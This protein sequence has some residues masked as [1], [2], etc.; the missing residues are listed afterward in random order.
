MS[1]YGALLPRHMG[2]TKAH[3]L[4]LMTPEDIEAARSQQA[5]SRKRWRS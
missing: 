3:P 5:H 4:T 2:G 1:R